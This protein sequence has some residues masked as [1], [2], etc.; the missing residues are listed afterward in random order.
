[1]DALQVFQKL[2]G[3]DP[4]EVNNKALQERIDDALKEWQKASSQGTQEVF[5]QEYAKVGEKLLE[6]AEKA[7]KK[8]SS[9]KVRKEIGIMPSKQEAFKFFEKVAP[10]FKL[11]L[12]FH[13]TI[14]ES[15]KKGIETEMARLLCENNNC[16]ADKAPILEYAKQWLEEANKKALKNQK[17]AG[18]KPLTQQEK[19]GLKEKCEAIKPKIKKDTGPRVKKQFGTTILES[20]YRL[21]KKAVRRR[22]EKGGEAANV[23]KIKQDIDGVK[24]AVHG[25]IKALKVLAGERASSDL[26]DRS[27]SGFSEIKAE[28]KPKK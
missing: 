5:L 15:E 21:T 9:P 11:N 6:L 19:I 24:K 17:V 8:N 7:I 23:V 12:P 16:Y 14:S 27:N 18:R 4:K 28:L 20:L 13:D 10:T 22:L 3:L 25:L 26:I 2:K 1:M